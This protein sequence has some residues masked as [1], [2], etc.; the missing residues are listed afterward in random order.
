[1]SETKQ[2]KRP[3]T[4]Q[5]LDTVA[6]AG[7]HGVTSTHAATILGCDIPTA[8]YIMGRLFFTGRLTRER[9]EPRLNVYIEFVY[10]VPPQAVAESPPTQ[11]KPPVLRLADRL[12][13]ND[14]ETEARCRR[15]ALTA[16]R[17]ADAE[18]GR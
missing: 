4:Q 18:N 7:L 12:I 9:G 5:M 14:A 15:M 11:W 1:M 10:R 13:Q 3:T 8:S 2:R 17:L 16:D 6:S